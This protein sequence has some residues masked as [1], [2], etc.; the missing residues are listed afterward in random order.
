M[1]RRHSKQPDDSYSIKSIT[2]K[3]I[4]S[5]PERFNYFLNNSTITIIPGTIKSAS[6][7][8][9]ISTLNSGISSPYTLFRSQNNSEI[10]RRKIGIEQMIIKL[11]AVGN[12][13]GS[14]QTWAGTSFPN[15]KNIE[16][17][18]N[19]RKENDIQTE[20]FNKT[21]EKLDPV[22]PEIFYYSIEKD[23]D[24]AIHFLNNMKELANNEETAISMLDDFIKNII[25][26][27][28]PF[29]GILGME[30]ANGYHTLKN[31]YSD[32]LLDEKT[33]KQ[34]ENMARLRILDMVIK[35]GYSQNDYLGDN[36]LVNP[37]ITG[38]YKDEN[39][40]DIQ[41]HILIIDFGYASKMPDEELEKMKTF[42][43]LNQYENALCVFEDLPR[44]GYKS[45]YGWL[46][47]KY[48]NVKKR[49]QNTNGKN[50]GDLIKLHISEI[51]AIN[52]RFSH[53]TLGGIKSRRR[54]SYIVNKT[55][56]NK[57]S[58]KDK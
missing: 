32:P 28:I 41:G 14:Q 45:F 19:F 21:K 38:Y 36:I 56:K 54:K 20:I 17:E 48:N 11:V 57:N 30:M 3:E 55:N 13:E 46:Y 25:D 50:N 39:G 33:I 5:S 51:K 2:D 58:K 31:I 53:T 42:I 6:G 18:E 26:G 16:K 47:F 10:K 27:I 52:D 8:I 12:Y 44:L 23:K 15:N 35:S 22:C 49:S 29:L 37:N 1:K 34:Y 43:K 7:V 40:N 9:F 4:N 24:A